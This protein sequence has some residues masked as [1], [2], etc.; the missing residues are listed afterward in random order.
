MITC[1]PEDW[2]RLIF[3]FHRSD[4]FRALL[5]GLAAVG[6]YTGAITY[7]E[8]DLLQTSFRNTTLVHSLIGFVLSMML[9]FRTNT[10]CDR[11]W[12]GRRL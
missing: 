9:I 4:P 1:N 8:N 2:W 7:V 12:E 11:W 6:F 5:P 10:A 3:T